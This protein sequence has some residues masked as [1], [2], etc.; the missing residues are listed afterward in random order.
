L[1][2]LINNKQRDNVNNVEKKYDEEFSLNK[3]LNKDSIENY[4][5]KEVIR[6]TIENFC[7]YLKDNGFT[8]VKNNTEEDGGKKKEMV[9]PHTD[10]KHYAKV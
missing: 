10:K 1:Y 4:F 5:Q 8:I 2:N 9:C 3:I 6:F 7:K